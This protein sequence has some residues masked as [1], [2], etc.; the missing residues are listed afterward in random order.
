MAQITGVDNDGVSQEGEQPRNQNAAKVCL[1][2]PRDGFALVPWEHARFCKS[3]ADRVCMYVYTLFKSRHP[4][5]I[6][7]KI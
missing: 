6:T 4:L 3:C 5:P 7:Q 1:L 2:A